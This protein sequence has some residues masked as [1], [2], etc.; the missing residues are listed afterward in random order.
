MKSSTQKEYKK[1]PI[2]DR[3]IRTDIAPDAPRLIGGVRPWR[4]GERTLA[5][6]LD[7]YQRVS[8]RVSNKRA[9]CRTWRAGVP[10]SAI[11]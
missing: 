4:C 1:V 6:T 2:L 9:H 5:I 3:D 7:L 10:V 11:G 8:S